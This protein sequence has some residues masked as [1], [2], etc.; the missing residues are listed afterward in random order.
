MRCRRCTV[1]DGMTHHWIEHIEE[2]DPP[3]YSHACKHC[4]A[5]GMICDEC[6]EGLDEDGEICPTCD[7]EAVCYVRDVPQCLW[8]GDRVPLLVRLAFIKDGDA[9]CCSDECARQATVNLDTR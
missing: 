8:C 3:T 4:L 1:C 9:W 7:G 5:V 2:S 6:D